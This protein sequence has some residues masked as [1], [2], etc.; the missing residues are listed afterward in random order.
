M[1]RL[2][3]LALPLAAPLGALDAQTLDSA[4]TRP[5]PNCQSCAEWNAPHAP[6]R[7]FGNAWY[8]GTNGLGAILL[9]SD[10]GHVLIDGGLAETAPLI[11]ANVRAL[12]FRLED[13][14]LIVNSHAHYDHAAGIEPLRRASGATVAASPAS[15]RWMQAGGIARDDPQYGLGVAY[16]P[17]P[18]VRVIKDG[19]TLRVGPTALTA[20][21]TPGHTPGGTSWSWRSCEGATCLDFVY[22]DSQTPISADGFSFTRNMTYPGIVRDFEQGYAVLEGLSCDVLLTPHPGA[23]NLWPRVAARDSGKADALVDREACKRYAAT[24]RQALAKRLATE[25]AAKP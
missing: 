6:F 9:T 15:A 21:F 20:H 22:A 17:V 13:V 2:L 23:S 5:T 18:S 16:A 1:R 12:G 24:A 7:L 11:A 3:A 4:L 14:K 25:S 10:A 19:E 8:V